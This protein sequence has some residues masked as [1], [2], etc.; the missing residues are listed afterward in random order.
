[1]N[2]NKE[3]HK[4][5]KIILAAAASAIMAVF[6]GNSFAQSV[7][8]IYTPAQSGWPVT[9][10]TKAADDGFAWGAVHIPAAQA[11]GINS[12]IQGV[13]YWSQTGI[14]TA[15][16]KN[17]TNLNSSAPTGWTVTIG[18][19]TFNK[20]SVSLNGSAV[21]PSNASSLLNLNC[22]A[23]GSQNVFFNAKDLGALYFN[24]TTVAE[25]TIECTR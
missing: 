3:I 16:S 6:P 14:I 19:M 22:S 4:M 23:T 1:M 13:R 24:I 17:P 15:A 21:V 7:T 11:W 25:P 2:I 18:G 10:R 8:K 12:T 9:T 5:N 20:A